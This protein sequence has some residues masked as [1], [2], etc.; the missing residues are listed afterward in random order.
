MAGIFY[1]AVKYLR[2]LAA[3]P[4]DLPR[5]LFYNTYTELIDSQSLK[6]YSAAY[7]KRGTVFYEK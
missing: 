1:P 6:F 2:Q 5:N 4:L 3:Y 7:T